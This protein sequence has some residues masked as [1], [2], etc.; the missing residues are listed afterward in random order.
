M[1]LGVGR[2]GDGGRNIWLTRS[3]SKV[4]TDGRSWWMNAVMTMAGD[5]SSNQTLGLVS[6]NPPKKMT[7]GGDL[8]TLL[9]HRDGGSA[10]NYFRRA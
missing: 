1:T 4:E 6:L 2:P 7:S 3:E 10:Q 5:G 9:S 8:L